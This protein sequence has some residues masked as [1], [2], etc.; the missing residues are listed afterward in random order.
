MLLPLLASADVCALQNEE[1]E[2][3][4][5][6]SEDNTVLTFYYD[7]QKAARN[8]MGVGPFTMDEQ[9]NVNSGWFEQRESITNAVFDE[10]FANCTTLTSTAWW[11]YNFQNLSSITGISNLKTD[12]VTDMGSMFRDCSGLTSLDVTGFKTDNVTN[13]NAMFHM[14]SGLTSLDVTGF[15]T[16]KV[17]SMGMMFSGCSGLTSLDVTGFKTDNVTNMNAMFHTCSGLTSLDV[18]GFKTDNVTDMSGM[19]ADC[20]SLTSLDMMGFK[21]DKVT[22]MSS[23]FSGCS[24][25]TSLDVTGFKT[26]NV[27]YMSGMFRGCSS[28][29]SLDVTGFKTDNVKRMDGMFAGCSSLTSLDVTG[30]KTENVTNMDGMFYNCFG[31]TS[32]DV[33]GFKTD[34]VTD[35]GGMFY[36]CSGLTSLDVT[37][38]K[39]DNVTYMGSMFSGCSGLTS[40]DVTGFKTDNVTYMGWMFSGC[41][42]LKTIYAGDGWSTAKVQ[43]RGSM[44]KGCT[45]LVGGAGTTYSADHIDHTY[46]HI[47]GGASNPGYF[48]DKN[49]TPSTGGDPEP[50]PYAVLSEDN[51]VLTFYYDDQKAAR[52]GMGVGPFSGYP[53]Y[54]S[55]YAQR[56]SITNVVFEESFAN[57]NTLTST[58][59]W[60][61]NFQNLSSITGISNLKTDKVTDMGSM[62]RDCSGL[63]SL[64]VTGFKTDNVTNMNGMFEGCSSLTSLDVTGF[65]TDKVTDMVGMFAGCS[66]L[67]SLDVTGFKTDNVRSMNGM[68]YNCSSLTSLDVTGF[69]TDNVTDMGFMFYGCS[70]LTSLDVTGFKTDNVTNMSSMFRDCSSLT[71]LDVTGF[72]TENVT[73]MSWMFLDC[74]SLKT[75]YAGNGWSTSKVQYSDEMFKGCTSLVGGAGTHYDESHNTDHTYARIDGGASNPGYFTSKGGESPAEETEETITISSAGQTTWCS[76]Y[77]LDFTDIEGIKAYTAGGYDRVSG[78]IWLMRVK[79]VPANEGIL[80]MGTPG[81]YHVPHKSTGTYYANLMVGTLQP[82][83]INETDGEYTNYYLSNGDSGVGFYK[84]NGSVDLKANRAYLPLLKGTAQ[85]GTRFIGLGFEDDG[86]SNLTPALSKG[87]GAWYTLQGQRVAKPGKGLYI[88]NGKKVVIK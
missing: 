65:K 27:T 34:N 21:T 69:K 64:D 80:I 36:G 66:G 28:L 47:D 59:W 6:L 83:T 86:T 10:S 39:T 24:S 7:D 56:E 3:Y 9:R 88:H 82:I 79:Q 68:F 73:N 32:L 33:M 29:T 40:L 62:F 5:V 37:G 15:K 74:S 43:D 57:C 1:K 50:E 46:A 51:T 23:M 60:F 87:E 38:F 49:A 44:F 16:D 45:S 8:G 41:S 30:F 85:A 55:W 63:T 25:L 53:D 58:A 31:L 13:M 70:G 22:N 72:K 52:N 11:F 77:D 48:T 67:T 4:A 2:P 76:A 81:E 75:I 78:T 14:C 71:S 20:P 42:G 26:D 84:V 54:S 35:M 17:T 18:T 19:F 61:S 12:K